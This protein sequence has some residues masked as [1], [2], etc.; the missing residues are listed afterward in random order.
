MA[1]GAFSRSMRFYFNVDSD[2]ASE[3]DDGQECADLDA[4]RR[5]AISYAGAILKDWDEQ[6]TQRGTVLVMRVTDE[7]GQTAL[8]LEMRE[9]DPI[10]PI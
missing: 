4:A 5:F 8:L 6:A 2:P 10:E 9:K 3:D 1:H 7:Q